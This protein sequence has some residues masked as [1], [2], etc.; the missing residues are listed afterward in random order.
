MYWCCSQVRKS[1]ISADR[2]T[3]ERKKVYTT[4][5]SY[6]RSNTNHQDRLVLYYSDIKM[7]VQTYSRPLVLV[8]LI[9]VYNLA[10]V[11][12]PPTT[13]QIWPTINPN[14][15]RSPSHAYKG[16]MCGRNGRICEIIC[17]NNP[18]NGGKMCK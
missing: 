13:E 15:V 17:K 5:P 1:T 12:C 10:L 3:Y 18:S 8:A 9:L 7:K 16:D 6:R 2:F 4:R 11:V 14:E